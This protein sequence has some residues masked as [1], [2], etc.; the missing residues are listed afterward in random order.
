[1]AKGVDERVAEPVR[2]FVKKLT[3]DEVPYDL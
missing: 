2:Q 3:K 1:L